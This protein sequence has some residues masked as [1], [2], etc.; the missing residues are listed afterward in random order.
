MSVKDKKIY[1]GSACIGLFHRKKKDIIEGYK[2]KIME[3][4]GAKALMEAVTKFQFPEGEPE[5]TK[6]LKELLKK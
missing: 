2:V 1:A 5:G 6:H 3:L 4:M